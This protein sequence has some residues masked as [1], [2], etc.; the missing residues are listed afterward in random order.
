MTL[1]IKH[2]NKYGNIKV[3]FRG[4]KF[5]SKKEARRY[6]ELLGRELAG[7]ITTLSQQPKY[8]L[9]EGFRYGDGKWIFPI[10]CTWDFRYVEKGNLVVEDVKSTATAKG[11]A[12]RLRIKLFR[13]NY[14]EVDFREVKG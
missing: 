5:D 3:N 9:Q 8:V 7:E 10:T 11:E 2:R 14:P 4:M 1:H 12:Y 6:Q 13:D